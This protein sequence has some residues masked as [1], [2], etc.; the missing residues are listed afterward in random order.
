MQSSHISISAS[1]RS[2]SG[3]IPDEER[4]VVGWIQAPRD[5]DSNHEVT[6]EYQLVALTYAGGW[7]RLALPAQGTTSSTST[8]PAAPLSGSPPRLGLAPRPRTSSGSSILG[9]EKKEKEREKDKKESRDCVL[10]EFRRF[11]R[12]DGW[13]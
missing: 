6:P 9:R 7:Y 10:E 12:W 8:N 11:G 2:P 5:S 3:D 13:G 1:S 4:C